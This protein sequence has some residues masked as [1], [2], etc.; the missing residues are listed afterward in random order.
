MG[1]KDF[2]IG[3][4]DKAPASYR[5]MIKKVVV[6]LFLVIPVLGVALVISQKGF[7]DHFF[8]FGNV[9]E[10][11]GYYHQY[12]I[13]ILELDNSSV[14]EGYSKWAILVGFGK[15]GAEGIMSSLQEEEN[16]DGR[17][18]TIR[19]SGI[20]GDQKTLIELTEKENSLVKVHEDSI[21]AKPAP[22]IRNEASLF[23]E[24]VDPK[25]Y[26]GVMK[27]GEGKI[28]RSCAIRC[29]S[30]GI[31]PIL[32]ATVAND[33]ILYYVVLGEDGQKINTE[34]LPYVGLPVEVN[35]K[36]TASNGWD[37]LYTDASQFTKQKAHQQ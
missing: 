22:A 16:L 23:G 31:P 8:E 20:F 17:K 3:W 29:I 36:T 6:I 14:K 15:F 12:P 25:C 34:I 26:F 13:P 21:P 35:G 5:K 27:P 2:Y 18:I 4:K 24:I 9:K 33:Q 11:T 28:H 30:G 32:K 1:N 19:G 7:N 37:I 10:Y